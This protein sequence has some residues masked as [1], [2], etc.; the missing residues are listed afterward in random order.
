MT[1]FFIALIGPVLYAVANHTDKYLISKYLK[2]GA[3]GSLII[4]SALFSVVAL[5]VVLFIHP[6]VF[7]IRAFDAV[8]LTLNGMVLVLPVLCYF[9][10]LHKDDASHVVPFYQT[11]PIFGFILGYFFLGETPTIIQLI[12]SAVIIVGALVLSFELEDKIRF[13]KEVVLLMMAASVLYAVNGVVFKFIALDVGFWLSIFWSLLGQTLLGLLF[14]IFVKSY[15]AQFLA[16]LRENKSA[17]LG[18]NALSETLFILA[19]AT[20][21]YATLLAPIGLV[22]LVNSFQPFFV[23]IFAI[24]LALFY[25]NISQESLHRKHLFQK[26]VGI[27]VI[28]LGT[29]I[30]SAL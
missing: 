26:F 28:I 13:K 30:I 29:Y 2:G 18:L 10:A 5:P 19:E 23:F 25:P 11:I 14:L 20:T 15:R 9:Y 16:M 1:W 7:A 12:G 27:G 21:Q 17:T 4:F 3:V 6:N 24:F 22:F 8:V